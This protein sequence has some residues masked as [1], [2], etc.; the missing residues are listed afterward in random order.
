MVQ[1]LLKEL[2]EFAFRGI[3]DMR[4]YSSKDSV[5]PENMVEMVSAA[6][7]LFFHAK[8]SNRFLLLDMYLSLVLTGVMNHFSK[9]VKDAVSCYRS[10]AGLT[11]CV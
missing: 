9:C 11:L 7:C 1:D 8:C 6:L 4:C 2:E 5:A 3:P 10:M